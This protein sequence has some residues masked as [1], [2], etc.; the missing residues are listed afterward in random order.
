[1]QTYD[2]RSFCFLS[3]VRVHMT[4]RDRHARRIG[5]QASNSSL[6]KRLRRY[7]D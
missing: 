7:D 6:H 2:D 5:S 4:Y 1:M 3:R